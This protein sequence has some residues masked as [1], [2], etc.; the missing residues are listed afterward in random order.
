MSS[1][2]L[3][4]ESPECPICLELLGDPRSRLAMA[5]RNQDIVRAVGPATENFV[6]IPSLG[7]LTIG[8][9]LLVPHQH[10]H[11]VLTYAHRAHLEGELNELLGT[12]C[13]RITKVIPGQK[14]LLFEHCSIHSDLSLC[15]TSH[16]H[17]HVVPL[18]SDKLAEVETQ[19]R[20]EAACID[21]AELVLRC[22]DMD[23]FIYARVF[24]S[25]GVKSEAFVMHALGRPSQYLRRILADVLGKMAW[26]WKTSPTSQILS[27]TMAL[28]FSAEVLRPPS[29]AA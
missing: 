20:R 27:E 14:Y 23:D 25:P 10:T 4:S 24:N 22:L 9:T 17:L 29:I 1:F 26:D 11:S 19:L 13:E 16:A 21:T 15:S 2:P 6:A 8:H 12:V 3:Y 7:P 18:L 28:F 5:L